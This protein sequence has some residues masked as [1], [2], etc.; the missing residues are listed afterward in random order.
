MASAKKAAPTPDPDACDDGFIFKNYF[1]M[2]HLKPTELLI[3]AL[4]L[5]CTPDGGGAYDHGSAYAAM[6]AGVSQRTAQAVISRLIEKGY[7][8]EVGTHVQGDN[9]HGRRLRA[10]QEVVRRARREW[11]A[12]AEAATAVAGAVAERGAVAGDEPTTVAGAAVTAPGGEPARKKAD[13]TPA[14]GRREVPVRR[15]AASAD[16]DPERTPEQRT[17]DERPGGADYPELS[18]RLARL[19][20]TAKNRRSLGRAALPYIELN[21]EGY[22]YDEIDSAWAR[23]QADAALTATDDTYYPNLVKWLADRGHAG[24]RA[25]IC[26]E[27]AAAA[28]AAGGET[29]ADAAGGTEYTLETAYSGGR[30]EALMVRRGGAILG[31]LRDRLER[32]VRPGAPREEVDAAMMWRYGQTAGVL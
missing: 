25:M 18:I 4:V 7:I 11:R 12:A 20:E 2:L 31:P 21:E 8:I 14:P 13:P 28:P 6:R 32:L 23:R 9:T 22:T 24:C 16:A 15:E 3:F 26:A 30:A 10:N 1:S 27:R 29:P 5:S 17:A 19:C